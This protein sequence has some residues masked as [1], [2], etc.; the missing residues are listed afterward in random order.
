MKTKILIIWLLFLTA[1]SLCGD[2][3]M[4]SAK[5]QSRRI[6]FQIV[7][8]NETA[9][10]RKTLAQTT[11]EGLPGTDF[12]IALK[13]KN[14]TMQAKFLTDLISVEQLKIRAKL[15]TRRFYGKSPLDLPLYEEDA[16]DKQLKVGFDETIVLLPFGRNGGGE[17]LKIE[18]IPTLISSPEANKAAPIEIKFDKPL[19]SSEIAIEAIKIPHY[20]DVEA[21]LLEDG[22]RIAAG[23]SECLLEEEQEIILHSTGQ[24]EIQEFRTKFT[25]D[26]YTRGR[27][28]DLIGI[29]FDLYDARQTLLLS[30]A[31]INVPD[32]EFVYRLENDQL[33]KN[34]KYELIFRIRNS[35]KENPD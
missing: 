20:F 2:G 6:R 16:Q 25:V 8:I 23:N 18:I 15:N 13:T 14:F 5:D 4:T 12:N 3:P 31:G 29:K 27:P 30:A 9:A 19:A 32:G 7:T 22:K 1:I 35:K 33:P 21:V 26:K 17:T 24:R 10:G 11:I 34:K 28:K